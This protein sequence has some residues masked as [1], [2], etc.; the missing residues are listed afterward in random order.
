MIYI[1]GCFTF[2]VFLALTLRFFLLNTDQLVYLGY[3]LG[4]LFTLRAS[5]YQQVH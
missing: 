1:R 5:N 3:V 4:V 2:L